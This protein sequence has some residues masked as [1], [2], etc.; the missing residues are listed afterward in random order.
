[1]LNNNFA[2][3]D[4]SLLVP[5]NHTNC[6]CHVQIVDRLK[7][8]ITDAA[9]HGFDVAIASAYRSVE[10]QALI[11]EE[12]FTGRRVVLDENEQ[13]LDISEFD[14][15]QKISRICLFSALPGLSRHHLGTDLDIYPK[16][17][18]PQN[19]RL[20]LTAYEYAEDGYFYPFLAY[21]Q[22]NLAK[23]GFYH[24]YIGTN[25]AYEPWHISYGSLANSLLA[26]FNLDKLIMFYQNSN[27][28]YKKAAIAYAKLHYKKMLAL[29]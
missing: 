7:A 20:Q 14:D 18:L 6:L 26:N 13:V 19:K 10:R 29:V 2:L 23:F 28:L 27:Y 1:M 22:E 4:E 24:P 15:Y 17:L 5:F 16:N 11:V 12:K 3:V 25:M 8:L 21:M 9:K